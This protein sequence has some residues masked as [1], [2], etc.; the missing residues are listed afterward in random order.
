MGILSKRFKEIGQRKLRK[1][2]LEWF[3]PLDKT[4]LEKLGLSSG[5][6]VDD[7]AL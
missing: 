1:I 6:K 3:R 2:K 4:Q 5:K 7:V